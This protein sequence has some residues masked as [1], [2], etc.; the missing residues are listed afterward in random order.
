MPPVEKIIKQLEKEKKQGIIKKVDPL[1]LLL[2]LVSLCIF[3]FVARPMIQ[4]IAAMDRTEF[5]VMMEQRKKEIP[6]LIIDSIKK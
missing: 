4:L 2:N 5:D 3:P 1:Q 6:R